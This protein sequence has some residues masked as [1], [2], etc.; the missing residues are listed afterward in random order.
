[1]KAESYVLPRAHASA[2]TAV[3]LVGDMVVT[4]GVDQVVKVWNVDTEGEDITVKMVGEGY[5]SVADVA[6]AVGV[7]DES[8]KGGWV[9]VGGVGVDIWRV[10][11]EE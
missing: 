5:T 1:M 11:G 10:E 7:Q 2:V 9:V 8:G 3:V 6:R 4:A